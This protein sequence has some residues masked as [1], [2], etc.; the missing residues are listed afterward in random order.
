MSDVHMVD[1]IVIMDFRFNFS[2]LQRLLENGD[3]IGI[4]RTLESLNLTI[5]RQLSCTRRHLY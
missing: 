3:F 2:R 1:R 5:L 4:S